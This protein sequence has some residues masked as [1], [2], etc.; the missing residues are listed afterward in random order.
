MTKSPRYGAAGDVVGIVAMAGG[1]ALLIANDTLVKL[2]AGS[3]PMSE[4]IFLRAVATATMLLLVARVMAGPLPRPDRAI[5][6]RAVLEG[7]TSFSYL[8]A[9]QLIP[10]GELAGLQQ[11]IPLAILVGAALV[12]RERIGWQGWLATLVGL[13]G[14]ALIVRPS[15]A[16]GAGITAVGAALSVGSV[17]FSVARDLMTRGLRGVWHPAFVAGTSQLAM[18]AGAVCLAPVDRWSQPSPLLLG[19]I[20]ASSAFL[21]IA[22]TMLVVAFRSGRLSVVTPF[23]Y[24]GLIAALLSGYYVWGHLPDPIALAGCA[25]ISACG[26]F[27]L[28]QSR[29]PNKI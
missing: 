24:A 13:I 23:R 16:E 15:S 11:L 1:N 4:V 25:I 8:Y 19:Q 2:A 21:A 17:V 9:L 5:V 7:A 20:L 6:V 12:F 29:Q 26:L 3:L 27:S 14:A 28:W 18:I 10:I 22:N